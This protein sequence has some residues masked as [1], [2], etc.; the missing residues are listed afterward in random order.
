MQ[1]ECFSGGQ[2]SGRLG[3]ARIEEGH[4]GADAVLGL[5]PTCGKLGISFR[6][7]LGNRL[8]VVGAEPPDLT[9]L[10][11]LRSGRG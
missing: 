6:A 7:R 10:V 3:A 2:W 8:K 11:R 5:L 4:E 9:D 1:G